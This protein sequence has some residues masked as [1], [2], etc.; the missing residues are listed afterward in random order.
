MATRVAWVIVLLHALVSAAHGFAHYGLGI[1]LST[2]QSAYVLIVITIGPIL[3]AALL[4]AKRTHAGFLSLIFSMV[5]S[6]V[7]GLYWHY[8]AMSPDNV[9]HLHEGNLQTLFR[10]T[11]ALLMVSEVCGVAVGLWGLAVKVRSPST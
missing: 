11:A 10:S 9:F 5:G 2:F 6:L 3:A 8:V 4:W 1:T 7:F